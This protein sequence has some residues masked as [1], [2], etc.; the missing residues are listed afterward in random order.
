M[1]RVMKNYISM[2]RGINVSGR[3]KIKMEEL[4]RLYESLDFINVK[5]Y[6]QSGNVIFKSPVS[7]ISELVSQIETNI[8]QTYGFSVTVIIRTASE[9]Q[10]VINNNPFCGTRQED[11]TKLHVT[12]LS[13]TPTISSLNTIANL[14]DELDEWFIA[15]KEI[16]LFC[17]NGYGRTKLTNIFFEKKLNL[18]ATT[19]N[20]NT[21]NK[22]YAIVKENDE[23]GGKSLNDKLH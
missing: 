14:K 15:G 13:D 5:T 6:I 2:L 9:F 16:F 1:N 17:P 3:N 4:K 22:L 11:T 23:K 18:S 19:R 10:H 20:W 12:F 8:K 21:V 7:D